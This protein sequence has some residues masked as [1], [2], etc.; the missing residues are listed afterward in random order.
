MCGAAA[1]PAAPRGGT[2]GVAHDPGLYPTGQGFSLPGPYHPLWH[3]LPLASGTNN[4]GMVRLGF[5]G[6]REYTKLTNGRVHSHGKAVHNLKDG[7]F[8][9]E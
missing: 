3:W 7:F 1:P 4:L 2:A 9:A 5:R 8:L 6:L